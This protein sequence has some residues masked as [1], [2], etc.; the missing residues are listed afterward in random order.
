MVLPSNLKSKISNRVDKP[1]QIISI[2]RGVA[3]ARVAGACF[4]LQSNTRRDR[5]A[6]CAQRKPMFADSST[7]AGLVIGHSRER[8]RSNYPSINTDSR[9]V[10]T[11]SD[12]IVSFLPL[13]VRPANGQPWPSPL[14][15]R[16]SIHIRS[17]FVDRA[18]RLLSSFAQIA[19]VSQLYAPLHGG[20]CVL[21]IITRLPLIRRAALIADSPT[22]LPPAQVD[23]PLSQRRLTSCDLA[24]F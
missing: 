1:V 5:L 16:A 21:S 14:F 4:S 8:Q 24:Y 10:S 7:F 23:L 20:R 12:K 19:H 17:S 13:S 2:D 9:S 11:G 22:W 6:N 18:N 15:P 3:I